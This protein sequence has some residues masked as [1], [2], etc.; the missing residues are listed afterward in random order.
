MSPAAN[1][2]SRLARVVGA[3]VCVLG[4]S[5]VAGCDAVPPPLPK[6]DETVAA[7]VNG[8]QNLTLAS[9]PFTTSADL[10]DV[11]YQVVIAA[12]DGVRPTV[13]AGPATYEQNTGTAAVPLSTSYPIGSVAWSYTSTATLNYDATAG[14]RV[15][16]TPAIVH[17][18]LDGYSRLSLT[19]SSPTRGSIL[20]S[21]GTALVWNRPVYRVGI[22]KTKVSAD[23]AVAS[24]RQLAALVGVDVDAFAKRVKSGGAQEFVV[25]IT[26]REGQVPV[27]VDSIPG[28]LTQAAIASLGPSPTW[29]IGLL[30][31]ASDVTAEDIANSGGVLQA[32]DVIG[33]SGLQAR[34]D[35][36]LR[37]L[38]GWTVSLAPR[39]ADTITTPP[40]TPLPTSTPLTQRKKIWSV[41][42]TPGGNVTLTL[43]PVLQT[44]A[45]DVLASQNGIAALV[46]LDAHTGALK[47]AA[48]SPAA[49]AN[50]YATQGQYAPGSTFKLSTALAA[51]RMGKTPDSP[52]DCPVTTSVGPTSFKNY[53]GYTAG[54]NGTITIRKAVAYSCNTAMVNLSRDMS[55]TALRNA[56]A[57]L[58]I[59]N[60]ADLGFAGFLGDVP[61]SDSDTMRASDA[62]GQGNI[63]ASPLAMA[64]EAASI[65]A[66]RTITPYLIQ[67]PTITPEPSVNPGGPNT[68]VPTTAAPTTA[69][70]AA[71]VPPTTTP[72]S[73]APPLSA[74]EAAWLQDAMQAVVNIGTATSL[75]GL[76]TGAK[77]GTA[78]FTQDGKLLTHAWMI[79]YTDTYA[80]AVFVNEG[81]SG[82]TSAAPLIKA[83]LS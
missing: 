38:P 40:P 2:R 61:P 5:A 50:P 75:K 23:V 10:A 16:W 81:Q 22:D 66:G 33:K 14:W 15:V 71:S 62:F 76:V 79:A 29:A 25:A 20:A 46:V 4:L 63:L 64:T 41:D 21:D 30:G 17:P 60:D 68:P 74:Q 6:A 70:P 44:K 49:G 34:Y 31:T 48:N 78:E 65:A 12:M 55:D 57:S 19:A 80:I 52:V 42:P 39:S 26:L 27:E 59:G 35:A 37:G 7:L 77:S 18:A 51:F 24:A 56:A 67:P 9:V 54:G 58:G 69:A 32:G 53:A 43:D 45:E 8:L 83:L 47:A 73:S 82:G 28:T 13:T 72:T 11:E 36:Y 1:A 3:L